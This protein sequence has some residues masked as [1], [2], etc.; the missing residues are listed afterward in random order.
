MPAV[1]TEIAGVV[2]AVLHFTVV[3]A[4]G[5]AVNVTDLPAQKVAAGPPFIDTVGVGK[6]VTVTNAVSETQRFVCFAVTLYVPAVETDIAG[7]V[8]AVLHLTVV[9]AEGVAVNV[10]D[11]P[12]QNVAA[13][14]PFTDTVGVGKEVT[15]TNA[16][17]EIHRFV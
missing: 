8:A 9:F 7:V 4:E 14:P 13:G 15:V 3:F 12:V 17:S 16:V 6:E 10:T 1:E 11:L 5:V 2:A